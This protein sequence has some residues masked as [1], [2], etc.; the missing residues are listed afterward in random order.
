[1]KK[2]LTFTLSCLLLIGA[3]V[4]QSCSSSSN[5]N[6]PNKDKV[7]VFLMGQVNDWRKANKY[8]VERSLRSKNIPYTVKSA[9]TTEEQAEQVAQAAFAGYKVMIICPE[10][11]N[12]DNRETLDDLVDQLVAYGVKVILSETALGNDYTSVVYYDNEDIGRQAGT[13]AIDII[14]QITPPVTAVGTFIFNV[15]AEQALSD[16]RRSGYSSAI[17]DEFAGT[18]FFD[19]NVSN[20]TR[21]SGRDGAAALQSFFDET[22]YNDISPVIYAQDD[23]IAMGVLEY[24]SETPVGSPYRSRISGIVGCG[25]S[26]EFLQL[27]RD[28]SGDFPILS[29]TL[30]SPKA[31]MEACVDAAAKALKGQSVDKDIELTSE[32]VDADNASQYIDAGSPY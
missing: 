25:G 14:D 2:L 23:E 22:M 12:D 1:M 7:A 4:I 26:Q 6:I 29:T 30:Y 11:V 10:G 17:L 9:N 32:V 8:Y 21:Q 3:L 13:A 5:N 16:L 18:H 19:E 24:I 28:Q 15:S 31:L 20:Y 27:I